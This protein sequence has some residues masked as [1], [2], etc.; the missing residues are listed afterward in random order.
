MKIEATPLETPVACPCGGTPVVQVSENRRRKRE[1]AGKRVAELSAKRP[2][3]YADEIKEQY[4]ADL[5]E[6]AVVDLS[7]G[8]LRKNREEAASDLQFL[9][10]DTMEVKCPDC[11]A[12][13]CE[14][15]NHRASSIWNRAVA[16]LSDLKDCC[17]DS[18]TS[19]DP[20]VRR[21]DPDGFVKVRCPCRQRH[22]PLEPFDG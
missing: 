2:E 1:A 19:D 21:V 15:N 12:F 20:E 17:K 18:A 4:G 6:Q 8:R 5:P 22:F 11:G 7:Q 9:Q 14:I 3:D 10:A 13:L 16:K